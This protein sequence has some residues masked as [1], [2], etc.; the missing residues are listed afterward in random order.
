MDSPKCIECGVNMDQPATMTVQIF[1]HDKSYQQLLYTVLGIHYSY[2][3]ADSSACQRYCH[4]GLLL[5]EYKPTGS[6]CSIG[7]H[8][9]KQ[10]E[11]I[12]GRARPL[13]P[14]LALVL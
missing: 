10:T 11:R 4:Q 8:Y 2:N 12:F 7:W 13:D 3:I 5:T 14:G 9:L 1:L 6:T